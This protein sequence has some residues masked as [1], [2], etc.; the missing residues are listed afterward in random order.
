MKAIISNLRNN[1]EIILSE[2][3][4]EGLYE[5]TTWNS[6]SVLLCTWSSVI[7]CGLKKMCVE[8]D[9][10]YI[11]KNHASG[12]LGIILEDAAYK[13]VF[14]DI[15]VIKIVDTP[16]VVTFDDLDFSEMDTMYGT[17]RASLKFDNNYGLDVIK[18]TDQNE[19]HVNVTLNDQ[20]YFQTEI[21][22]DTLWY[23]TRNEINKLIKAVQKL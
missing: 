6:D 23:Q 8:K 13:M 16:K 20:P 15:P 7:M 19:Y 4:L 14:K 18:S 9:F 17:P 21:A 2:V 1:K 5:I 10:R 3:D 22:N 11:I 12:A